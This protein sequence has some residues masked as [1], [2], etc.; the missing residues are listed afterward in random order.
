MFWFWKII[1]CLLILQDEIYNSCT[2]KSDPKGLLWCSTKVHNPSYLPLFCK[3]HQGPSSSF[4]INLRYITHSYLFSMIEYLI[5]SN[6]RSSQIFLTT[7]LDHDLYFFCWIKS[8]SKSKFH[9]LLV[10]GLFFRV[11][12]FV[13][14]A[15][16]L[17]TRPSW[18]VLPLY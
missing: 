14:D 10:M 6:M 2:N 1:S 3:G 11:G 17:W 13:Q 16:L 5:F 4:R 18:L 15:Y 8:F 7:G 12:L 9:Y